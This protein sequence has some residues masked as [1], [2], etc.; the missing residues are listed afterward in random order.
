M[1]SK[2]LADDVWQA[3]DRLRRALNDGYWEI[4]DQSQA[5]RILA[6][7]QDV[8]SIQDDMDRDEIMSNT[9]AY[10]Q[11]KR[12]VDGVNAKLDQLKADLAQLIHSV[13]T[14]NQII[15]YIDEATA[16]ATKFFV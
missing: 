2:P 7:A 16:L 4:A 14:V 6:L 11:L 15:G 12:R 3:L 5:D 9:V 10:Q 8:D 13:K 1:D